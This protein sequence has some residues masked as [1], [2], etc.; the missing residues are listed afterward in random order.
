M[1]LCVISSTSTVKL[2]PFSSSLIRNVGS[3]LFQSNTLFLSRRGGC[4]VLRLDRKG[5]FPGES[6]SHGDGFRRFAA[7][8]AAEVSVKEDKLP[9]DLQVTETVEANSRVRDFNLFLYAGKCN[10]TEFWAV[11]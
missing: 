8:P 11:F 6:I 9:A 2:N 10:D 4:S 5:S 3:R 7:S 1:E